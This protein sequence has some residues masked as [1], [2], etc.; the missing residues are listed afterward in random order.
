M[1][2]RSLS[3]IILFILIGQVSARCQTVGTLLNTPSSSQDLRLIA[4]NASKTTYL[5][6][7]CGRVVNQWESEFTPGLAAYLDADGNLYR[8][9]R[10]ASPIFSGGGL[11]GIIEKYDWEG[12][13]IW[14]LDLSHDTLHQHHD[15]AVMPNGNILSLCWEF[16][17]TEEAIARGR[18]PEI[19]GNG[20]WPTAIIESKYIGDNMFQTIWAWHAWDHLVQNYD[21]SKKDFGIPSLHKRKIDV[22]LYQE[23][24]PLEDWLH[25]NSIDYNEELDQILLSSR[26]LDEIYIIDHGTT[27]EESSSDDGGR[28]GF[29]GDLLFRFGNAGNFSSNPSEESF[30]SKQ[31]DANWIKGEEDDKGHILLFNNKPATTNGF[32][33]V[34]EM[35]FGEED[36]EYPQIGSQDGAEALVWSYN[37][38]GLHDLYS[39]SIS[40]SQR[41]ENG[42][43]LIVEGLSGRLLEV[44]RH[45][46]KVWE[47][48][49]PVNSLGP[50]EQGSTPIGNLIFKARSYKK[51]FFNVDVDLEDNEKI[52]LNP[53][54]NCLDYD[55]V[56]TKDSNSPETPLR[57]VI[58]HEIMEIKGLVN[59]PY[60]IILSDIMGHRYCEDTVF[61]PSH[62]ISVE[63]L[64]SGFYVL[65]IFK[66]NRHVSSFKYVKPY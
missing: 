44:D 60:S 47:Y 65:S 52:E 9:G 57:L 12:N 31:H 50:L 21:D 24:Q 26:N 40:G 11:G 1:C 18:N 17:S 55:I 8:A 43:T 22:N 58:S 45:G 56:N 19:L 4:P 49:V 23:G 64:F 27:W 28:R 41:L 62:F 59:G 25:M 54:D 34:L 30:F 33:E 35:Y 66:N 46:E 51:S 36:G 39:S 10:Q 3:L 7:V 14:Q 63:K 6:D 42:N 37:E 32:S 48:I 53:L 13:L 5:I 20:I 38:D 61:G 16:V 15:F 29:G 2:F